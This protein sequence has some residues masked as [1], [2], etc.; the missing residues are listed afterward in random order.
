M[1]DDKWT[2]WAGLDEEFLTLGPFMSKA[3]AINDGIVE[4]ESDPFWVVQAVQGEFSLSGPALIDAQYYEQDD[5]FD[6]DH[7]EPERCGSIADRDDADRVLQELLDGW[8]ADYG[9][10]FAKPTRFAKVGEQVWIEPTN[11]PPDAQ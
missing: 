3:D 5:L 10:T 7:S 8:V 1:A 11:V 9:H 2:W 6:Y 4:F